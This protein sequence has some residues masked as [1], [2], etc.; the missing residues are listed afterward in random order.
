MGG[1]GR[2]GRGGRRQ[3]EAPAVPLVPE[4]WLLEADR[5]RRCPCLA[6]LEPGASATPAR[7]ARISFHTA[8][9]RGSRSDRLVGHGQKNCRPAGA[10]GNGDRC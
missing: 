10:S 8:A 1:E 6:A 9:V 3:P 4:R 2:W 7:R 5:V